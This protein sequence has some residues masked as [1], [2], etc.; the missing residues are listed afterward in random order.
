MSVIGATISLT[1][2]SYST[3]TDT[4]GDFSFENIPSGNCIMEIEAPNLET[5]SQEVTVTEGQLV[6]L[7]PP[8]MTIKQVCDIDGDGKK[9]LPEA[10]DALQVVSGVKPSD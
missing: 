7:T 4:N 5:I 3:V 1:D 2:T 6:V 8:K 10:I 9:G